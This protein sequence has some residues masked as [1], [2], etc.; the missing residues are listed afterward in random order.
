MVLAADDVADAQVGI[1]GAG[2]Q[3]VGRIAIRAEQ[4][5]IFD[6]STGLHLFAVNGIGE[7]NNLAALARNAEAKG[8]RLSS[9]RAAVA[10][11]TREFP[12][13]RIKQ[14]SSLSSRSFA[15]AG[16]GWREIAVSQAFL[17]SRLCYL[18]MQGS[19]FGLFVLFVPA[20]SQPLQ[21]FENGV[22]RGV[23]I[24]LHVGV[25]QP[26]NHRS[27]IPAGVQ[28]VENEG[29]SAADVEK[30]RRRWSK[31]HAWFTAG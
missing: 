11:L 7:A 10:F 26:Q 2:G 5:K 22:D 6:I 3:M 1:V 16:M 14:P 21:A 24:P 23:G 4:G 29:A 8:K 15:V 31:A 13:P 9:G 20:E 19:A 25:I 28:P 30:S 17:E 18:A 12:H 27:A